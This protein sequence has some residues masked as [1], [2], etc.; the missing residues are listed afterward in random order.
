MIINLT[1]CSSC[2]A[3]VKEQNIT[4]TQTIEGKVSIV[5]DVPALVCSQCG[6]ICLTPE[7][8]NA[9]QDQI[10]HGQATETRQVP[11]FRVP[12]PTR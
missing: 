1:I 6:E 8:V 11:V 10:E 5:E 2:G 4:Y 12:Q 7:T 3:S 9:I